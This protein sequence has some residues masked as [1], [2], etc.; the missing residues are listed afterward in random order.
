MLSR[1]SSSVMIGKATTTFR[2][3][4]PRAV[5]SARRHFV[6]PSGADRANVVDVPPSYKEDGHISPRP[7]RR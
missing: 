7:G 3:T 5:I 6:Q 1:V 2:N 4:V